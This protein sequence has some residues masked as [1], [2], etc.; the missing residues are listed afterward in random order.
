MISSNRVLQL[1]EPFGQLA[2]Q[3]ALNWDGSFE[4]PP[5]VNAFYREVGPLDLDIPSYGNNYFMPR[6]AD[7]WRYQVGHRFD[8]GNGDRIQDWD[9][10]WLVIADCGA[11]PF[12]FSRSSGAILLAEHGAGPWEPHFIFANIF[13]MGAALAIVGSVVAAAGRSLT[14]EKGYILPRCR[15]NALTGLVEFAGS[16][17]AAKN[18]LGQLGWG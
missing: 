4:L 13:E 2:P 17:S 5:E 11:D 14:N 1:L 8:G 7:L 15:A 18:V 9:D 10:D 12:I 6:L 3:N 16:M